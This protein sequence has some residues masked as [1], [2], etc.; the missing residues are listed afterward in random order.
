MLVAIVGNE[1][2]K[3]I[4]VLLLIT[5][6]LGLLILSAFFI[7]FIMTIVYVKDNYQEIVT[8]ITGGISSLALTSTNSLKDEIIIMTGKMDKIITLLENVS[9]T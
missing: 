5:V 4:N 6:I 8:G 9:R 7:V 3:C 2:G 1:M